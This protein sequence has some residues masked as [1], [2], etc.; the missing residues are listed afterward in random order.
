MI[1]L[2]LNYNTCKLYSYELDIIMDK[3]QKK[4]I[5]TIPFVN[6]ANLVKYFDI[7]KYNI[8]FDFTKSINIGPLKMATSNMHIYRLSKRI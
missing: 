1:A 5:Q 2:F 7:I 4:G 8:F 6:K 3:Y